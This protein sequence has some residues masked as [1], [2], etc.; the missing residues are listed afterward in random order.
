MPIFAALVA[1]V[2]CGQSGGEPSP[3]TTPVDAGEVDAAETP[4][5]RPRPKLGP[6]GLESLE[7]LT[8]GADTSEELPLVVALHG[9]G[10]T[11]ENFSK[12]FDG[13]EQKARVVVPSGPYEHEKGRAWLQPGGSDATAVLA[14]KRSAD[15][16]ASLIDEISASK[17]TKG[18]AI[19]TGFSQGGV[20]AFIVAARQPERLRAALPVNGVLPQFAWPDEERFYGNRP[21]I[22]AFNG[23]DDTVTKVADI[24]R[25]IVKLRMLKLDAVVRLYADTAHAIGP[26]M[27]TDLFRA[28]SWLVVGTGEPDACQPCP[29]TSMDPEACTLCE[30]G[31]PAE[32]ETT[33]TKGGQP[34]AVV[35]STEDS[36]TKSA[37][38]GGPNVALKSISS[39]V[40][41]GAGSA[42]GSLS[43]EEIQRVFRVNMSSIRFCYER[44]VKTQ[45]GLAGRVTVRLVISPSGAVS[46]A[47]VVSSTI[48]SSAVEQ[49]VERAVTRLQFPQPEGGSVTVTYPLT[50]ASMGE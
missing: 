50:F 39:K 36:A 7:V 28:L 34:R 44:Q 49:C 6:S 29:G 12:L 43:R 25:C 27:K 45:P 41:H 14:L 16:V 15:K 13:F 1:T 8:G 42:G 3:T 18:K 33:P 17:A 46:S 20:V 2:G 24:R 35:A 9:N 38:S 26:A 4:P 21:I 22:R 5:A 47:N 19:V 37:S 11:P 31:Q 23:Q 32:E 40:G 48:G 30:G 10:G